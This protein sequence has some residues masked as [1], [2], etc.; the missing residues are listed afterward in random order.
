[1]NEKIQRA[2]DTPA[3]YVGDSLLM[4]NVSRA[5]GRRIRATFRRR[6]CP[7]SVA[8]S[9]GPTRLQIGCDWKE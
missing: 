8:I 9:E 3:A 1:M 4:M 2:G 6:Y 7:I 5:G